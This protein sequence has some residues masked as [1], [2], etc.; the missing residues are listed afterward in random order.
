[1][2]KNWLV[3]AVVFFVGGCHAAHNPTL[4][5]PELAVVRVAATGADADAE[6]AAGFLVS[7]DGFIVTCGHMVSGA[8]TVEVTIGHD[9]PVH[10]DVVETDE[11]SDL[12]LV[13]VAGNGFHWLP[14]FGGD[15]EVG[16]HLRAVRGAAMVE[17]RFD[18][19]EDFGHDMGLAGNLSAW[20][21]G[22]PLIADDGTVVGVV[23]GATA[24]NLEHPIATP[25]W[26]VVKL[27]PPSPEVLKKQSEKKE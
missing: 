1:M 17:A 23:R 18:H 27:M 12:A 10:G 15:V 14:M 26:R 24:A 11:G 7:P 3:A 9:Q 5:H 4:D 8:K 19:W 2:S 22:T 20:D 6:S 13:K 21:C 25:V 16:M